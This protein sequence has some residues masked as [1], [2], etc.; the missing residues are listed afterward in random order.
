MIELLKKFKTEE[1]KENL[2]FFKEHFLN[3]FEVKEVL[4]NIF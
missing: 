2:F 4:L 1:K 3:T